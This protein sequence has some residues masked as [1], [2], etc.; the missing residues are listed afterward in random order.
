MNRLTDK[1]RNQRQKMKLSVVIP[2]FNEASIIE[3]AARAL[4]EALARRFADG[5]YEIIFSDDGST[6]G[7]ADIV[8]GQKSVRTTGYSQ[9]RGK[10]A[11]V[12][13][14]VGA[15]CGDIIIF[16]DCD[17]AY[18]T[19]IIIRIYDILESKN[20]E[21]S[22]VIGSRRLGDDG[23]EGYTFL[24]KLM[25]NVFHRIVRLRAG[26]S[27]SDSQ[28]GIKGF[29]ADAA[30]GIFTRLSTERFAFDI[31]VLL[32]ADRLGVHVEEIPAKIIN[33]R[34]SKVRPFHDS[35]A[36]LKQLDK[37]K[38]NEKVAAKRDKELQK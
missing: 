15:A 10:G 32:I 5:E 22:A 31:E 36:M 27:Y 19:D 35:I 18:G 3:S 14:G 8:R 34:D 30:H 38:K 20:A 28:C 17:L 11:A 1:M 2:V 24:R 6:D 25:S 7:C 23:Y 33:H 37:I 12:R 26:F 13:C 21:N 9:N 29:T 4:N 16:T